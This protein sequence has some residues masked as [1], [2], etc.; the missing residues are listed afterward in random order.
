VK[1]CRA[2]WYA[3]LALTLLLS[4]PAGVVHG[5]S[6]I[7]SAPAG[8][9]V[10]NGGADSGDCPN[11][12]FCRQCLA[13]AQAGSAVCGAALEFAPTELGDELPVAC[14]TSGFSPRLLPAFFSR[15]PPLIL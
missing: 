2:A 7:L 3:L 9:C 1:T 6:H 14:P 15:G 12:K 11:E 10:D 5:I 8:A 13:I 4:Q